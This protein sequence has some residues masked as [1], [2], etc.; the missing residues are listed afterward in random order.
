VSVGKR[1]K[2]PVAE[3]DPLE[4]TSAEKKAKVAEPS[5]DLVVE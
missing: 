1:K 2:S 3:E 4:P 5:N